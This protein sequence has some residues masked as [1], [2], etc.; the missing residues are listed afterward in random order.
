MDLPTRRLGIGVKTGNIE[1][2]GRK[3]GKTKPEGQRTLQNIRRNWRKLIL[4]T[5]TAGGAVVGKTT[6]KKNERACNENGLASFI[7]GGT[8]DSNNPWHQIG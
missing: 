8:L 7:S 2:S 5:E 3:T 4:Y 1:S 6:R